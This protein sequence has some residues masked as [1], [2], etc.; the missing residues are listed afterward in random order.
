MD[1]FEAFSSR[2][3]VFIAEF[4]SDCENCAQPIKEGDKAQMVNGGAVHDKCPSK[5]PSCPECFLVHGTA[6]VECD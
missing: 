6:Q 1:D 3:P 5:L 4:Y 2:G